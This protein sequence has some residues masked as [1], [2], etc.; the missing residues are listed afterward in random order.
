MKY[1]QK[2]FNGATIQGWA[3][4]RGWAIISLN[5]D[6]LPWATIRGGPLFEDLRYVSNYLL[7]PVQKN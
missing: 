2:K 7:L 5:L 4:I 3:I 6:E 1:N